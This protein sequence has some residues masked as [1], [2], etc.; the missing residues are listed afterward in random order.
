MGLQRHGIRWAGAVAV[1]LLTLVLLPDGCTRPVRRVFS[2]AVI[3]LQEQILHIGHRLREGVL[4]VRGV[5]GLA[6]ENRRLLEEVVHLQTQLHLLESLEEENRRLRGHLEFRERETRQMIAAQVVS[7]GIDSWWQTIRINKGSRDGIFPGQA[8][9]S[10]DGLVGRVTD[11]SSR[12][13]EVLLISDPACRVSAK[14]ARTGSFGVVRGAGVNRR[15]YPVA[16]M[17]FLHK[18]IPVRMGDE[19]V[20]S[21]LGG[22]FPRGIQIGY[23][24]AVGQ[25]E[26]GLY[27]KAD[28]V[29]KAVLDLLDVVFVFA[30]G[31][32]DGG[33]VP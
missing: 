18:D 2:G 1:L 5:G 16:Q 13:A 33:E 31:P 27:Q 20:T 7:R 29:P 17:T 6:E 12:M 25:D 9:V 21:G 14:I 15:G 11:V 22:L 10:S 3:P 32:G 24:E 28:I 19:V 4:T 8:V 23:V 30:A 26:A